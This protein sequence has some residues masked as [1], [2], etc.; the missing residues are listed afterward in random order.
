VD[1][2]NLPERKSIR[3]KEFDYSQAGAYFVTI[4]SHDRRSLF[5]KI[6]GAQVNLSAIG[7]CVLSRW[8]RIPER[9]P[10]IELDEFVAMPNHIH[11][12]LFLSDAALPQFAR[13]DFVQ[14]FRRGYE[15]AIRN[16]LDLASVGAYI[17]NNPLRW[18]LDEYFRE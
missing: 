7:K 4:C 17:A 16:E 10:A 18:S 5:G 9:F 11:G 8:Y 13:S 2:D 1:E 12:I 3:L 14:D 15:H 6:E